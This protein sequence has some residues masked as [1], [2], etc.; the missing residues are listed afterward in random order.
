MLYFVDGDLL[1]P[2]RTLYGR[3]PHGALYFNNFQCPYNATSLDDCKGNVTYSEECVSG[4][5]EYV[6]QCFNVQSMFDAIL[7]LLYIFYATQRVYP[8][9]HLNTIRWYIQHVYQTSHVVY[10]I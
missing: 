8:H 2:N 3:S 5:L 10:V 4:D 1:H 6:I 7:Y 9:K